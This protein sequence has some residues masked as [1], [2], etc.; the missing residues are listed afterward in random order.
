VSSYPYLHNICCAAGDRKKQLKSGSPDVG[1]AAAGSREKDVFYPGSGTFLAA[2]AAE[3]KSGT[4]DP[5]LARLA[6]D[7][8]KPAPSLE[9]VF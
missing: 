7:S 2:R 4:A 8:K 5:K 1:R 3:T 6:P 9:R